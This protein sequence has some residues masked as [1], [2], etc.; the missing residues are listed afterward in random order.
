MHAKVYVV[1]LLALLNSRRAIRRDLNLTAAIETCE[2]Y[3]LR[4]PSV[5]LNRTQAIP[6]KL[7]P[8]TPSRP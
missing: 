5:S 3:Q 7:T 8:R 1:T 2:L 4:R 6:C